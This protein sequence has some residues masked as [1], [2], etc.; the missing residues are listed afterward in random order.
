MT[1]G[2][3]PTGRTSPGSWTHAPG[4]P[5]VARRHCAPAGRQPDDGEPIGQAPPAASGRAV[6]LTPPP[7]LGGYPAPD[8]RAVT[9]GGSLTDPRR[10]EGRRRNGALDT[11]ENLCGDVGRVWRLRAF[12]WNAPPPTW[13]GRE[14]NDA[15][16]QAWL[17]QDGPRHP[18]RPAGGVDRPGGVSGA[19][20]HD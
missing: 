20:R 17:T 4:Q 11:P 19:D 13:Y 6:E 18:M 8:R 2:P 16:V 14:R 15:L 9:A 3:Q 10:H 5:P 1:P 7:T 12:G